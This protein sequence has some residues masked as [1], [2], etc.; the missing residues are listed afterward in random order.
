MLCVIA[1][2]KKINCIRLCVERTALRGIMNKA[3]KHV[4]I[5]S[6]IKTMNQ[7]NVLCVV[8]AILYGRFSFSFA[9]FR[10]VHSLECV[11]L[12]LQFFFFH[13]FFCENCRKSWCFLC[14]SIVCSH[15]FAIMPAKRNNFLH[16]CLIII[17]IVVDMCLV[18][19]LAL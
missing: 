9:V 16:F 18:S 1:H 12:R 2:N 4:Q 10:C 6:N 17:N 19:S 8:S 15:S 14:R 13:F 3:N 5:K 7:L 11:F